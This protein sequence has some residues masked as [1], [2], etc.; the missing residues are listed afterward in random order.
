ME[1]AS[2][3]KTTP[4]SRADSTGSQLHGDVQ[5]PLIESATSHPMQT[6]CRHWLLR[7]D[8][9]EKVTVI[10]TFFGREAGERDSNKK[11]ALQTI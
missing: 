11:E 5:T 7:T 4:T 9:C 1:F 2:N 6:L 10:D 3:S 8:M